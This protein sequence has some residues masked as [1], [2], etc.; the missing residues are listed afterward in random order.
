MQ[1]IKSIWRAFGESI[2]LGYVVHDTDVT[3][4]VE[5]QARYVGEI[6]KQ[7]GM[8]MVIFGIVDVGVIALIFC[9]FYMIVRLKHTSA[10][11]K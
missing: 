7:M 10:C 1:E 4:A 6:R 2:Q 11:E 8:L 5:M 9:I 3:T